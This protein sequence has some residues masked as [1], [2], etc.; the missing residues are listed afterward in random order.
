MLV[1]SDHD[2]SE[3]TSGDAAVGSNTWA[4]GLHDAS[5]RR[6]DDEERARPLAGVRPRAWEVRRSDLE[7]RRALE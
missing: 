4:G 2:P 6:A 1:T 7:F 5:R 3:P